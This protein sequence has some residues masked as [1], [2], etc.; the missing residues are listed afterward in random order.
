MDDTPN[1]RFDM[2]NDYEGGQWIDGEYFYTNKRQKT[3]QTREDQLYGIWGDSDSDDERRGKRGPREKADLTRPVGFVSSGVAKPNED[4]DKQAQREVQNSQRQAQAGVGLGFASAGPEQEIEE[5]GLDSNL[6]PTAFGQRS[7]L[8]FLQTHG[9][10]ICWSTA[11][12]AFI[13]VYMQSGMPR[14]HNGS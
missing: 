5:D 7:A 2:N 1:E 3:V 10:I 14:L 6:F 4:A 8:G 12:A 11:R 9:A 13:C